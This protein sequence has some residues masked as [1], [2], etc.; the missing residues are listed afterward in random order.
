ML[1]LANLTLLE[2]HIQSTEEICGPLVHHLKHA[3]TLA[4]DQL[5]ME[6]PLLLFGERMQPH[7]HAVVGSSECVKKVNDANV[8]EIP[9]GHDGNGAIITNPVVIQPPAIMPIPPVQGN[10]P[11]GAPAA[12]VVQDPNTVLLQGVL[13]AIQAMTQMNMQSDQRNTSITLQQS[14]LQAATVRANQQQLQHLTNHLGTLGTEVGRA[15]ASHPTRIQATLSHPSA[16]PGQSNDPQQLGLLTRPL[17]VGMSVKGFDYGAY[18]QAFQ[19]QPNDKNTRRIDEATHTNATSNALLGTSTSNRNAIAVRNR[20]NTIAPLTSRGRNEAVA[21]NTI[22][23]EA[24][25]VDTSSIPPMIPP[26]QEEDNRGRTRR[27]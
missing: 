26:I 13:T 11:P 24:A 5:P 15:I 3:D 22:Y 12:G 1:I 4:L 23:S 18:V 7:Q 14:H 16:I 8:I 17:P 2:D 9:Y 19:P 21:T 6:V 25:A 27:C 20:N 10:G